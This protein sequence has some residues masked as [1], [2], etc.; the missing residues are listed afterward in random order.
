MAR[1]FTLPKEGERFA[2]DW[3]IKI[4][5]PLD[6]GKIEQQK[7]TARF[8]MLVQDEIDP[9]FE[10]AAKRLGEASVEDEKAFRRWGPLGVLGADPEGAEAFLKLA[11]LNMP[12]LKR[13]VPEG[14]PEHEAYS[15]EVLAQLVALPF[16]RKS[17]L[18][19]YYEFHLGAREK[20]SETPSP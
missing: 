5:V 18:V 15:E 6:G 3:P 7:L 12:D 8:Q 13:Q 4:D 20:N 19:G 14:K 11:I 1:L 17:L 10:A 9:I 16:V 2:A